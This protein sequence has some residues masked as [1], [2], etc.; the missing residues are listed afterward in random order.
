MH[1]EYIDLHPLNLVFQISYM[2]VKKKMY[3]SA[4][5]FFGDNF[6]REKSISPPKLAYLNFQIPE[7]LH[8]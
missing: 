4:S 5:L 3:C 2:N 6:F 1:L 7:I 8:T